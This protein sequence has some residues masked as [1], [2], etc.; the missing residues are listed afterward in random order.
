MTARSYLFVPGDRD[1]MLAKASERGADAIIADLED[2]VAP[3]RKAAARE[4]VAAWV[5]G[6][7]R[8]GPQI[9]VRVNLEPHHLEQDIAAVV[10]P[11]LSGIMLPKVH[12]PSEIHAVAGILGDHEVNLGLEPNTIRILPI[13]ET[14]EGLLNVRGLAAANRVELLMIGEF[15][16]TADLGIDPEDEAAML[17]L[18][19]AVV[20][21]SAAA[22]ISPP[23]GPVASDFRDLDDLRETTQQLA[24]RGFGARPAIHPAQVP[25]INEVFTPPPQEVTSALELVQRYDAVLAEGRGSAIDADGMMI[26]EAVVRSARRL[27]ERARR[28]GLTP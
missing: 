1:D 8:T 24:R 27:L 26:D 10:S 25:I 18:R 6:V 3:S 4:T 12:S 28:F 15:D 17:P 9:W 2:A 21:A 22:R 7:Q 23:L 20:V 5:A 11:R 16:L 19:L 14:A 13:V